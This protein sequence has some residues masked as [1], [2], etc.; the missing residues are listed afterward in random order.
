MMVEA[1]YLS[2]ALGPALL[3]VVDLGQVG[4]SEGQVGA[5]LVD[6]LAVGRN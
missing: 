3:D 2:C 4:V 6:V 1:T 5:G